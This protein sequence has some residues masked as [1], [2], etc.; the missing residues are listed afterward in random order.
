MNLGYQGLKD[1][2]QRRLTFRGLFDECRALIPNG[3]ALRAVALRNVADRAVEQAY[4]ASARKDFAACR[5]CLAFAAETDPG[6]AATP[7]YRRLRLKLRVGP[8]AWRVIG[9]LTRVV[10]GRAPVGAN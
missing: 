1:L 6:V 8:W 2:D 3:D 4:L 9:P 5:E 10:R 7:L